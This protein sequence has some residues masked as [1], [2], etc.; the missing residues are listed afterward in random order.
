MWVEN[1]ETRFQ[2]VLV[3][4]IVIIDRNRYFS[5]MNQ[6]EISIKVKE[7]Q[8]FWIVISPS[9]VL[10]ETKLI[11]I[12]TDCGASHLRIIV[13]DDESNHGRKISFTAICFSDQAENIKQLNFVSEVH[14]VKKSRVS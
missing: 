9:C 12:L 8:Q 14:Q 3:A 10:P 7:K 5:E 11:A 2:L 4:Y 1:L 13:D 6:D